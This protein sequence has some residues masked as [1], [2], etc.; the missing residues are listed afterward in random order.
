MSSK[1]PGV[2]S[3]ESGFPE[4]QQDDPYQMNNEPVTARQSV[5]VANSIEDSM[6]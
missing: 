6:H 5:P 2:L 4:Y 3:Q 1:E